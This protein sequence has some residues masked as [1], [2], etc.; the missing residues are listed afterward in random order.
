MLTACGTARI[1]DAVPRGG[2]AS[3]M[4][5][6]YV[7]RFGC[8]EPRDELPVCRAR[9]RFPDRYG[10]VGELLSR[11]PRSGLQRSARVVCDGGKRRRRFCI[12]DLVITGRPWRVLLAIM[13]LVLVMAPGALGD[14]QVVHDSSGDMAEP[15]SPRAD[16]RRAVAGHAAGG[17][18]KHAIVMKR[19]RAHVPEIQI[20]TTGGRRSRPE[21]LVTGRTV[22]ELGTGDTVGSTTLRRP[23]PTTFVYVFHPDSIGNADSYGWRAATASTLGGGGAD[24]APDSGYVAHRSRQ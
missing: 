15:F 9:F 5:P 13:G 21:F 20:N 10:Q 7:G 19:R 22:V 17:L 14:R 16:I 24:L 2:V 12:D 1:T 3:R 11:P 18:L 4:P 6:L 23:R 8:I